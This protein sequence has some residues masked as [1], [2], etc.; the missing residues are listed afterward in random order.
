MPVLALI[1][2]KCDWRPSGDLTV[3][4]V[5]EHAK[6]EHDME[7]GEKLQLDMRAFCPR[8]DTELKSPYILPGNVKGKEIHEFICSKC[9]RTYRLVFWAEG[10]GHG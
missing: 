5:N 4:V 8:D 1:C 6:V 7:E 2:P 10:T 3:G 9:R